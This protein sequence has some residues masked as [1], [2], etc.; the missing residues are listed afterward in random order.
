MNNIRPDWMEADRV[1]QQNQHSD[2]FYEKQALLDECRSLLE[3]A[4]QCISGFEEFKDQV[5]T[6]KIALDEIK[7]EEKKYG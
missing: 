1:Y 6:I 4:I 7:E 2:D 5:E 3:S